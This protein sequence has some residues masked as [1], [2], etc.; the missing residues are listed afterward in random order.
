MSKALYAVVDENKEVITIDS[1]KHGYVKAVFDSKDDATRL[2]NKYRS[3]GFSVQMVGFM[4]VYK[5]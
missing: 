4:K 1:E 3:Q 5:G 2:A